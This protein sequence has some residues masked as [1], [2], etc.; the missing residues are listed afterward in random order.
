MSPHFSHYLK[1]FS[2]ID[3]SYLPGKGGFIKRR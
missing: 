1:F 2:I 3:A